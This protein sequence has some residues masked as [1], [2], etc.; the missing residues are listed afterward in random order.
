MK[1]EF[2][3][4][5]ANTVDAIC[6]SPR[7][8]GCIIGYSSK[9][10]ARFTAYRPCGFQHLVV[11]ADGLSQRDG[12]PHRHIRNTERKAEVII[13]ALRCDIQGGRK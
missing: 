4:Q 6:A 1:Q 12:L 9:G 10:S 11:L 13:E 3:D 2:L 5:L 7:V 8:A